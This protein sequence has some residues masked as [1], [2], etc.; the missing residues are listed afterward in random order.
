MS[1]R[2]SRGSPQQYVNDKEGVWLLGSGGTSHQERQEGKSTGDPS[3]G[4]RVVLC[5]ESP[6][7]GSPKSRALR[8]S[9]KP[10]NTRTILWVWT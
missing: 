10:L 8:K 9:Y 3:C 6:A 7:W 2:K 5:G 1:W 4:N